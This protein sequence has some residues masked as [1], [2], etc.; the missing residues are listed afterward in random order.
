MPPPPPPKRR[1][2][3]VPE[4]PA[5]KVKKPK[6]H[7]VK[8]L[9]VNEKRDK[10]AELLRYRKKRTFLKRGGAEGLHVRTKRW[11]N[12]KAKRQRHKLAGTYT[13]AYI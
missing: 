2:K 5:I 12:R 8:H 9:I 13:H 3:L 7:A 11:R 4:K 1:R 6:F 10:K